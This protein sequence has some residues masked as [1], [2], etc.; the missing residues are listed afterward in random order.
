MSANKSHTFKDWLLATRPWSFPASAMPIVVTC[1]Y[2]YWLGE[3]VNWLIGLWTMLNVVLFHASANCWSDYKDFVNGVDREDTIGGV[4]IT[5]GAFTAVEIKRLALWL[6]LVSVASGIALM[7]FTGPHVLWMAMAACVLILLYPWFK[8]R[9][10]GDVDIFL[11]YS[12]LPML[13]TSYV[14]SGHFCPVV[15]W[16]ML[17]IGF[18][19]IG[20]LHANN[21]RDMEQDKRAK[22]CTFAMLVGKR[23][24]V[25]VYCAYILLPFLWVV[26]IAILGILPLWSLLVLLAIKV[27]VGNISHALRFSKEGMAAMK[28]VDEKTAQMQLV[29][30]LLLTI[31]MFVD[32]LV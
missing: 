8:Y 22:I 23:L 19:T 26:V 31:S 28:G 10:L 9:A 29:F 25:V 21:L 5:S 24:S 1:A 30:S 16:L 13:G 12:L 7:F 11:T 14:V 4:A 20:I 18:I 32:K 3:P 6:L 15:L 17:P 2:L 27:A